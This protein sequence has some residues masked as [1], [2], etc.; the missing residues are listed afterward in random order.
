MQAQKST[1]FCARIKKYNL[2]EYGKLKGDYANITKEM[3][4]SLEPITYESRAYAAYKAV[5]KI[6]ITKN[7]PQITF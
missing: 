3:T 1:P 2:S 6:I 7:K 5:K 4:Q